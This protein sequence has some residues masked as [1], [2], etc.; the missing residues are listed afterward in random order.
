MNLTEGGTTGP[1]MPIEEDYRPDVW[2]IL[3]HNDKVQADIK[4]TP[5][6]P[7]PSVPASSAVDNRCAASL[8][9]RHSLQDDD[10]RLGAA[11]A[12]RGRVD[13]QSRRPVHDSVPFTLSRSGV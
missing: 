1:P 9:M 11:S 7:S 10:Q 8:H 6:V 4:G 13:P 5:C 2:K 3:D 12:R